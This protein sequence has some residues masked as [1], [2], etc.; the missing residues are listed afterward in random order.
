MIGRSPTDQEMSA[1]SKVCYKDFEFRQDVHCEQAAWFGLSF[2]GDSVREVYLF[3]Y[4]PDIQASF[5]G[6]L[7]GGASRR[8]TVVRYCRFMCPTSSTSECTELPICVQL[9]CK[10]Y[11]NS[12]GK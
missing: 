9:I 6:S 12:G 2:D 5:P 10:L 4:T 7:P 1:L 3:N 11:A 8:Q